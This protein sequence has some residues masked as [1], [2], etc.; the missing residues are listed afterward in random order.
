MDL[1]IRT[2]HI[3][4]P[5][6]TVLGSEFGAFPGGKG[7]NQAIAA[8]RQ[9]ANVTFLG[10]VGKDD[11]GQQLLNSLKVEGIATQHIGMDETVASGV[12]LIT[13]D[14]TGE[15]CIVVAP[16]ANYKLTCD[17]IHQADI[18]FINADLVLLQMEI[19]LEAVITSA[20]TAKELDL[21]V[22]LNPAP[23][24]VLPEGLLKMVDFLIPNESECAI[25]SGMPVNTLSEIEA[26]A[27][28]LVDKGVGCVV[29]TLGACGAYQLEKSLPG[30]H[31]PGFIVDVEDTTAAGD[32]FV[33]A[34]G[35]AL[36]EGKS[37]LDA[38]KRGC[39]AGALAT[40]RLGAQPSI[41]LRSE[42]D[43][44]LVRQS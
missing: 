3:P 22:V 40:T 12:A 34:F 38:V 26:A 6:E 10:R 21:P 23:A 17:H 11:F 7:A 43:R 1:V 42:V 31:V 41:P 19:P 29:V 2:H 25:L 36:A 28:S 37:T 27:C 13:L 35:V 14:E 33:G 32:S 24:Q 8:A 39:A 5:G 16:G 44:L 4:L 20:V 15:N 30:I 18:A 9:G